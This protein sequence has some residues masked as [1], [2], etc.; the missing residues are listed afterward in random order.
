MTYTD[1]TT[2]TVY[3]VSYYANDGAKGETG[4][5]GATGAA[6][7]TILTGAAAPTGAQG[8]VGDIFIQTNGDWYVKE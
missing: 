2:S 3:S 1:S 6:G 7:S 8:K 4:A 5:T